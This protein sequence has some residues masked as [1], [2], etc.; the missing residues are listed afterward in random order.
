[1]H[2]Q[3][4]LHGS[5]ERKADPVVLRAGSLT[6][7]YEA[8]FL[9][10]LKVGETEIL[11]MINFYIRDH[12]W[13]TIPMTIVDE[14]I[15]QNAYSF[16]I[17]YRSECSLGDIKY[18]WNCAIKGDEDN[19]TFEIDGE[20][21]SSFKRN[22]LGFTVLHPIRTCAGKHCTITHANKRQEILKFPELINPHQPFVDIVEMRWNPSDSIEA[23]LQFDGDIF[24]TE[25][26]RNWSDASYKTYCTPLSRPFP[27]EVKP[28]DKVRQRIRLN[29]SANK[30]AVVDRKHP[31]TFSLERQGSTTFP[32]IGLSWNNL[33]L[34]GK[35]IDLI[36]SLRVDYVRMVV[37]LKDPELFRTLNRALQVAPYLE[38]VLFVDGK[39][40]MEFVDKILPITD[41]IKQIVL[42]PAKGNT[43]QSQLIDD[44]VLSLRKSFPRA[45]IGGGTDAF[46]TELNRERTPTKDLDFVIFSINP[47]CHAS[48]N[49]TIIENLEAQKDIVQSCRAFV[50][51]KAIHVGP[52]TFKMRWNPAATSKDKSN[53][54]ALPPSVDQRHLS[55]IG[56]AWTLGSFKYLAE[57]N[58]SSI[59]FFETC[60]WMG[61]I[62]H[63]EEPWPETFIDVE[64]SVYPLYIVLKELLA[65]RPKRVVRLVSNYPLLV[66][67]L[68][69]T[70]P[71]GRLFVYVM[72]FT[73]NDQLV[74]FPP[75]ARL[76][77]SAI[78][79]DYVMNKWI[80]DPEGQFLVF[81]ETI[82]TVLLP[83]YGIALLKQ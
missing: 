38:L 61:L 2:P 52:V 46:F 4:L 57:N 82:E 81:K 73:G 78:I 34:D 14:Q 71:D 40:D 7:S 45:K 37:D 25:D 70:D 22:R 30:A 60:G 31:L 42:L 13:V 62:P 56:A 17:N 9:R 47:Q 83:P 64:D 53:T 72:N 77:R 8:G 11:R 79:D 54:N 21:A 1:M 58:V 43:T 20:S 19:I 74:T 39:I 55:M 68:A 65:H 80:K 15:Q 50:G 18:R 35:C 10:Y 33:P 49:A 59:T 23:F 16:R 69:L 3:I 36:N 5:T 48:D 76:R 75:D 26:Q 24:E 6:L 63:P 12:N 29:V 44:C 67:G 27:V 66:D 41:R 32:H 28:G 51:N